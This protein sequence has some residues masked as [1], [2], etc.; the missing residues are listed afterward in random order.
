[1]FRNY[2]DFTSFLF[3]LYIIRI[4]LH[5]H[6]I[7]VN[8]DYSEDFT[9]SACTRRVRLRLLAFST[10]KQFVN[11]E[12]GSNASDFICCDNECVCI[13]LGHAFVFWCVFLRKDSRK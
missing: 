7:N 6:A 5:V 3:E 9:P 2:Y 12:F 4:L 11:T 1:M 8:D 10:F 13:R